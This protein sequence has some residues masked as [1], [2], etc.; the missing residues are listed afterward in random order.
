MPKCRVK[1]IILSLWEGGGVSW[2]LKI[3][4]RG[5]RG[6]ND[7]NELKPWNGWIK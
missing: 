1:K 6:W 2:D 5:G 4:E 7:W 3:G